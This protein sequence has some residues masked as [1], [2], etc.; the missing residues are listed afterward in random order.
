VFPR[1]LAA[2][3]RFEILLFTVAM[4]LGAYLAVA[5]LLRA[6]DH[7]STAWEPWHPLFIAML[8]A[9]LFVPIYAFLRAFDARELKADAARSKLQNDLEL[10]CQQSVSAIADHCQDASVND[11]S[12]QVWLCRADDGF[13]RRAV[14]MLP[15]ARPHSGIVWRKGKGIAGSAWADRSEFSANLGPLKSQLATLGDGRFDRL[16]EDERY[17]MTASEVRKTSHYAG[18]YAI[19]LFALNDPETT[20]GIFVIDYTGEDDGFGCVEECA[21]EGRVQVHAA[22][23]EKVLTEARSILGVQWGRR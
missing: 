20:L 1:V 11:L 22:L 8:V 21:R 5:N 7:H 19:P 9:A 14:F 13:D 17:G 12:V 18:I 4:A 15:E 2:M 6:A 3:R 23:V 16:P 10:L